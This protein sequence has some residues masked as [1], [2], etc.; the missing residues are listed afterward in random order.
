MRRQSAG[1]PVPDA[2]DLLLRIDQEWAGDSGSESP[3]ERVRRHGREHRILI[4]ATATVIQETLGATELMEGTQ[5]SATGMAAITAG[6]KDGNGL[7]QG[8][9]AP[10]DGISFS[11]DRSPE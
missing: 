7:K 6:R 11:R 4:A 5:I 10:K 3:K 9:F 2:D 8:D 1:L